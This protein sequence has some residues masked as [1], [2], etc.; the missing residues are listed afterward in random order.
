MV[1][2]H[3][4]NVTPTGLCA[5]SASSSGPSSDHRTSTITLKS[6]PTPSSSIF[7]H[8]TSSVTQVPSPVKFSTSYHTSLTINLSSS[9]VSVVGTGISSQITQIPTFTSTE[10]ITPTISTSAVSKT[11]PVTITTISPMNLLISSDLARTVS[12]INS[13]I[14]QTSSHI[15]NQTTS[16]IKS[17]LHQTTVSTVSIDLPWKENTASAGDSIHRT[18][19]PTLNTRVTSTGL[20]L[21]TGEGRF[22]KIMLTTFY[23]Y[24]TTRSEYSYTPTF[25]FCLCGRAK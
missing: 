21:T 9:P 12:S 4:T 25:P 8:T 20:E 22:Q 23:L 16:P 3:S 18:I 17:D 5:S 14:H 7:S 10:I 1:L 2:F 13:V 19:M 11:S 6:S 15:K 24:F